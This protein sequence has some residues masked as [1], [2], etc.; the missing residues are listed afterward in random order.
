MCL[1][2]CERDFVSSVGERASRD[3]GR[4]EG[5][6]LEGSIRR[7]LFLRIQN[8]ENVRS[9]SCRVRVVKIVRRETQNKCVIGRDK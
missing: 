8:I 1:R 9:W 4:E 5:G 3:R 6:G 2:L 7:G